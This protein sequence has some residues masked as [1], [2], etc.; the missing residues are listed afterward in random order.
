MRFGC[1]VE[2]FEHDASGVAVT[3]R[4]VDSGRKETWRAQYLVGCDGGRSTIRRG[5]GIDFGGEDALMDVFFVG[6][7]TSIYMRI[8]AIEQFVGHRRAWMYLTVNPT[9]A[10]S[11]FRSTARTS[12]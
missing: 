8:P 2:S 1:E 3:V 4:D 10:A 9:R 12:S 6:Q 11:S 7:V 5:L